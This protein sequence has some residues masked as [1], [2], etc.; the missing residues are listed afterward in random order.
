[1]EEDDVLLFCG[2][3]PAKGVRERVKSVRKGKDVLPSNSLNSSRE[4]P[5]V[6]TLSSLYAPELHRVVCR[7]TEE[8]LGLGWFGPIPKPSE[9][10]SKKAERLDPRWKGG[11]ERKENVQSTETDQMVPLWPTYVPSRSPLCENLKGESG[12]R[13]PKR[14]T[15]PKASAFCTTG[16]PQR[17]QIARGEQKARGT[18]GRKGGEGG[19]RTRR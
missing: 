5:R 11:R 14:T 2:A 18:W 12:K 6:E 13:T 16:T 8:V 4:L 17:R 15:E 1:V 7:T 10:V 3:S 19:R 9:C